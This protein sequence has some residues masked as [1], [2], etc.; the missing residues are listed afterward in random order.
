MPYIINTQEHWFRTQQRDLYVIQYR[1]PDEN[2]EDGSEE[3]NDDDES[4]FEQTYKQAQKELNAWFD[5]HLPHTPLN[6]IGASEYS[7]W[8]TGGPC[9]F[10]ADFD[11]QGLALFQSDWNEESVWYVE[12]WPLADW[13][14]RI[15]AAQLLSFPVEQLQ[16]M[17]WWDT[18]QGILL[19]GAY[20][21]D[22]GYC[23]DE[24][25][26][27]EDGWW[28][29]QQLFPELSKHQANH[30]PCGKFWPFPKD[31]KSKANIYVEFVWGQSWDSEAY[32]NNPRNL[33]R[34][35]EAMCIPESITTNMTVYDD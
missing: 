22:C 6:I 35:R 14:K 32:T 3:E 15:D 17:R 23:E 25:L 11:T 34:L 18:P 16:K 19:L 4:P 20:T 5:E 8:I 2:N 26:S 12:V 7:G 1:V 33:Q 31:D 30:F 9:Y 21:S 13:K 10:S 29:L 28:K 24:F 27:L